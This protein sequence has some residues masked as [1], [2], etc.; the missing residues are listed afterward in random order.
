MYHGMTLACRSDWGLG[1]MTVEN[2]AEMSKNIVVNKLG[3]RKLFNKNTYL[4]CILRTQ[5]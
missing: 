4:L 1:E 2:V 5:A 3:S